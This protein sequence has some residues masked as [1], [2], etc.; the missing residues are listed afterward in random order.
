[1]IFAQNIDAHGKAG[2]GTILLPGLKPD[3]KIEVVDEDRTLAAEE[4]KFPDDFGRLAVHIYRVT[5]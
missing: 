1:V 4:G 5:K 2:K 3:R